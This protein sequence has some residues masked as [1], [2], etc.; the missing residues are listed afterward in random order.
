M[1]FSFSHITGFDWDKGNSEKNWKKHQVKQTEIE[2]AFFNEPNFVN[3]DIN[4][5]DIESRFILLGRSTSEKL[6]FIVFTIRKEKIRVISARSMSRKER[7]IYENFKKN[8]EI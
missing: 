5:S 2:E 6:L 8:T 7:N 1:N 4:H 3:L